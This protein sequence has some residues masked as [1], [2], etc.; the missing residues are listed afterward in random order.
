M[1]QLLPPF[2]AATPPAAGA[3]AP[4]TTGRLDPAALAEVYRHPSPPGGWLRTNFVSTIDGSVQGGD[5]RSGTIN[6]ESDH[7]VFAT[8]RACSDAV[9]AGA[10]T[11][12]TEGYRAVQLDRDQRRTRSRLGLSGTPTLVVITS[13]LDLDPGIAVPDGGP[14]LVLTRPGQPA[15]ARR[16]LVEAGIEVIEVGDDPDAPDL[17]LALVRSTLTERG[18]DRVLCEGGAHLHGALLA[19]DLVDE[20]CLTLAP[21]AVSGEG[22][23]AAAGPLIDPPRGFTL[24]HVLVGDDDTLFTR[25][26]RTR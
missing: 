6:T 22:L 24:T 14:V 10:E 20:F 16:R 13:S 2:V 11:V 21:I 23:R 1:R 26:R 12:R 4:A 15:T 8:L 9:M 5:G 17:D 3:D 7:L 19:A 18:L 25:Y